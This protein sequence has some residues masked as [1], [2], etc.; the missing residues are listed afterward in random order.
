[1]NSWWTAPE[2]FEY[3]R[4]KNLIGKLKRGGN[5][6][7]ESSD[8]INKEQIGEICST[9]IDYPN[10]RF[11]KL[12]APNLTASFSSTPEAEDYLTQLVSE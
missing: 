12:E 4:S 3:P 1:M 2:N 7:F 11:V 9:L 6:F 8:P 10:L 5:M